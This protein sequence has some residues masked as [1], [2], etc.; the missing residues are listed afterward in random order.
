MF[1]HQ[2]DS[3]KVL[4]I[5]I[6]LTSS[7]AHGPNIQY[8]YDEPDNKQPSQHDTLIKINNVPKILGQFLY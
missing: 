3:D 7:I 5:D 1:F 8:Y 6:A 2:Y 4:L